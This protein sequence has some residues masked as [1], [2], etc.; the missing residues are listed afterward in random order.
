MGRRIE[1][2]E[3]TFDKGMDLE[4]RSLPAHFGARRPKVR[5]TWTVELEMPVQELPERLTPE[6]ELDYMFIIV[7]E[8]FSPSKFF[9]FLKTNR[10]AI[11]DLSDQM[12]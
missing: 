11:E 8:V 3:S 10:R 1:A 6:G 12:T 5:D 4:E 2:C 7:G 9:W